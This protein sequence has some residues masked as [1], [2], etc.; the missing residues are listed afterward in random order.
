[1]G[2]D[3]IVDRKRKDFLDKNWKLHVLFDYYDYEDDSYSEEVI[4]VIENEKWYHYSDNFEG[5]DSVTKVFNPL[6]KLREVLPVVE[7]NFTGKQIKIIS[8]YKDAWKKFE[9]LATGIKLTDEE[10]LLKILNLILEK[11]IIFY[12]G[13][14]ERINRC[15]KNWL[16][17]FVKEN[18]NK[19][20]FYNSKNKRPRPEFF[21][22]DIDRFF[23]LIMCVEYTNLIDYT[24]AK[25]ILFDYLLTNKDKSVFESIEHFGLLD[26]KTENEVEEKIKSI[27]SKYPDKVSEY[28]KG[29]IGI[30]SMFMGEIM[31]EFKGK[32]NAKEASEMII[33][34]LNT[35]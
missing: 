11:K 23:D 27:I 28:K 1:M 2:I 21:E 24:T 3:S 12:E 5:E 17:G 14:Y 9:N 13:D 32:I 19:N 26:K 35:I 15:L 30:A 25:D 34:I 18:L 20:G 4:N 16:N 33:K 22:L 7:W 29:K 31:K 10:M 8:Y 6:R